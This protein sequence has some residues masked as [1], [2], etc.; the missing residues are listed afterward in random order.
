MQAFETLE[1]VQIIDKSEAIDSNVELVQE[2][3]K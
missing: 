1:Q 2:A 3:A